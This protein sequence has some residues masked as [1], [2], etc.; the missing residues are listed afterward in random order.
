[1]IC[2]NPSFTAQLIEK[3]PDLGVSGV[4]RI[5]LSFC[6]RLG[7]PIP[8]PKGRAIHIWIAVAPDKKKGR[9]PSKDNVLI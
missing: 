2:P 8:A 1:M 9:Y 7:T 6:L 5:P 4:K 3:P